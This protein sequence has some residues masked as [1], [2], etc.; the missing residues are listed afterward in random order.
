MPR[1]AVVPALALLAACSAEDAPTGPTPTY[2]PGS[3]GFFDTPFPSD[4]RRDP[5]GT[6]SVDGFPNPL[7]VVLVDS[8]LERADLLEGFGTSSPVY[9]GFDGE[10]DPAVMPTPGRSRDPDSPLVLVDVDPRSPYRG[11]RFPV[12]WEQFEDPDSA[13]APEH[14]LAVAPV[15]GWP[16]RPAT[17]YALI[18]TTG[19][20]RQ[21]AA[22]AAR[23][24]DPDLQDTLERIDLDPEDIA[25]ATVFTTQDPVSELAGIMWS[26]QNEVGPPDLDQPLEHL[27]DHST[28]TAWRTH[29]KSP[30]YTF[31][32]P[33]YITEGGSFEFDEDGRAKIARFDD[34]RL[35]V[36]TPVG[37][38]PPPEGWPVVIYQHGTGGA[39]RGFCD[40]E[41]AYEVARLLGAAGIIGLGID[42]PLHGNRPGADA[43]SDL[44]HF[45]IVNPDSAR[46][47]F[48]QGAI[49]L[50][51]LARALARKPAVF[52]TPEGQTFT[53]DPERVM[54]FG[55]SQGG[56]TGALAAP[57]LAGDVKAAVLSGAGGVLAIT[58]IARKDPLDFEALVRQLLG[59]GAEESL[60][61]LHPALGL[62]QTLVEV[63]DPVNYAPYW[64]SQRGAWVNHQPTP[65]LLTS[66]TL[67]AAT[68]YTTAVALAAAARLPIVGEPASRAE[69]V[70]MRAGAPQTLPQY[71]NVRAFTGAP[72]TSGFAQFYGG[73]H[74]VVF[75][76]PEASALAIQFLESTAEGGSLLWY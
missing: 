14:L 24:L 76:Q 37:V 31:G 58:V 41:G 61:P 45:N 47:N 32:E 60:S 1:I 36:C 49:D 28:Y 71:D 3:S 38:E 56:L 15:F 2:A 51:Y 43:A 64:F 25:I 57:F 44:A 30:V 23:P 48:R 6:I 12:Q 19:A 16:L 54:F 55:H 21:S 53:T 59:V 8:Y 67:D 18:V 65:I 33:P 68:P 69:A 73:T 20:A 46:T 22:W 63:T 11:E 42:Q 5:D 13:Y 35:A 10:L 9:V 34:M 7:G 50:A 26:V 52:R 66:G 39:Y 27:F 70:L 4:D 17:R 62:V 72:M 40:S 75:E 29:Y 74:F